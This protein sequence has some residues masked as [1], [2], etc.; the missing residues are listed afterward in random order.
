MEVAKATS[1]ADEHRADMMLELYTKAAKQRALRGEIE[2]VVGKL[3]DVE[4]KVLQRAPKADI[5]E[6]ENENGG[7]DYAGE[8]TENDNRRAKEAN[9]ASNERALSQDGNRSRIS[10]EIRGDRKYVHELG[11]RRRRLSELKKRFLDSEI[12]SPRYESV[13]ADIVKSLSEY[14]IEGY[15]IK[16][17]AWKKK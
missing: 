1:R 3:G 4:N 17:S 7:K 5:I 15:A 6:S 11:L 16:K 12:I 10:K 13:E 2:N 9:T 8:E 14:G